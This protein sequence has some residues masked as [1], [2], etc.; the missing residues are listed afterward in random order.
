MKIVMANKFLYRRGGAES[1]LFA[2]AELLRQAGHEVYYFSTRHPD[3][4]SV[5]EARYFPEY[6]EIGLNKSRSDTLQKLRI[7]AKILYN[8]EVRACFRRFLA[9]VQPDIVHAHL[10]GHHLGPALLHAAAA[11]GVP[12][13]QTLHD[14]HLVCPNYTLRRSQQSVCADT[15]CFGGRQWACVQHRCIQNSVAKSLV[16]AVELGFHRRMRWYETGI[17]R[18][19]CPSRFLRDIVA[20]DGLPE[21]QL[22]YLPNFFDGTT[23]LGGIPNPAASVK[24]PERPFLFAGRLSQEKGL[25]TLLKAFAA[26]PQLQLDIVGTGPEEAALRQWV[27]EQGVSNV[28]F[29]GYQSGEALWR[30]MG[31]AKALILPSEWYENAPMSI[32]EAFSLGVPVIGS[33]IG[34]IPEMVQPGETGWLFPC[35][36]TE[37]LVDCLDQ[38][39]RMSVADLEAISQACRRQ[40]QPDAHFGQKTHLER[41]LNL[42]ETVISEGS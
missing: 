37:A 25:L 5:E 9:E 3:N 22:I 42:Y 32:L 12:V 21:G 19:L 39:A 33:D 28:R 35:G 41:L 31:T 2:E 38:V 10:I 30:L 11:A 29:L 13:V 36:Q 8:P 23:A 18:F 4:L 14:Y 6:M 24:Q 17:R 16:G 7:A 26:R 40:V 20:R 1:V 15:R 27:A 34:G